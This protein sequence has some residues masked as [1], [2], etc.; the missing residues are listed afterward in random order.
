MQRNEMVRADPGNMQRRPTSSDHF[1]VV[2]VCQIDAHDLQLLVCKLWLPGLVVL[3]EQVNDSHPMVG[4]RQIIARGH[5]SAAA[6]EREQLHEVCADS[7]K[8]HVETKLRA[9]SINETVAAL[10]TCKPLP[11]PFAMHDNKISLKRPFN[12]CEMW[13]SVTPASIGM[14]VAQAT[15]EEADR[16]SWRAA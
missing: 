5:M 16:Q 6:R 10:A 7:C 13:H 3:E 2:K 12:L 1:A 4:K 9:E 8:A 14:C 11:E 15:V